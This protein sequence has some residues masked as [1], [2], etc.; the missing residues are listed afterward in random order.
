MS[1]KAAASGRN[2]TAEFDWASFIVRILMSLGLV[3]A[4]YNPSGYSF[5][6]WVHD[7][8]S[9]DSL[10]PEHL[11]VGILVIIGWVILI[12]ATKEAMGTLGLVLGIAL[13]A[14]IVWMLVDFGILSL[15]SVSAYTWVALIILAVMLGIGMSW[16]HIWRRLTGQFSVDEAG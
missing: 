7:S 12:N 14:G 10:G 4:T 1:D 2:V 3:L 8:Y 9:S 5:V 11:V 16:A 6:H 13:M 15:G